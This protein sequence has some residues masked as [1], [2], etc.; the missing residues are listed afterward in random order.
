[1]RFEPVSPEELKDLDIEISVLSP[2]TKIDD[3][4]QVRVGTHG[5]VVARGSQ[6]GLLLPQVAVENSWDREEFLK[7][8]CLK[9]G[10]PADDWKK[11][12]DIFIFEALIIH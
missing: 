11:G 12:A 1:M 4:R 9:A 3:P 2:L 5:L 6:R 8:A 10:L 7:Q